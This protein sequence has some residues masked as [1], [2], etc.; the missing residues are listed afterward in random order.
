MYSID[1]NFYSDLRATI[2]ET[3]AFRLEGDRIL[4]TALKV[5]YHNGNV[6]LRGLREPLGAN[7][8][9]RRTALYR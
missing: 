4:M 7:C 5:F 9:V 2:R 3:G 1:G 8:G 6:A